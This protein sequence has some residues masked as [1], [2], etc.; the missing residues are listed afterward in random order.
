M[1][2]GTNSGLFFWITHR[3]LSPLARGNRG[4]C[5]YACLCVGP[6]PACAGEPWF[7]PDSNRRP[8]AY[9]R[10]RGGTP[11]QRALISASSG[12]SPLARGNPEVFGNRRNLLRPIPACAGEPRLHHPQRCGRRAYPRLRGGTSGSDPPPPRSWGLSPLARGNLFQHELIASRCGPIPACA[13]EPRVIELVRMML[14]AYPRLRGG[15]RL[16]STHRLP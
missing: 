1:R 15:T 3:G 10:L 7:R 6:I 13:G 9:P 12:L 16:R 8:G 14:R 4:D 2:G 5:C 11:H